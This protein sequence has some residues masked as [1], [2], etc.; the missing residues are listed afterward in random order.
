MANPKSPQNV[1][2]IRRE[3]YAIV[4]WDMV[5]QD[6]L[7][8]SI[9]VDAYYIYKSTTINESD[10]TLKKIVSTTDVVGNVDTIFLDTDV[11]DSSVYRIS[12]V[13]GTPP[14]VV[15]SQLS[16]K[17]VAIKD[18]SLIDGK[19]ELIDRKIGRFGVGRFGE[20]IFA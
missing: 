8:A 18:A 11:N 20:S 2:C 7:G 14:S 1:F 6:E 16:N 13:V 12:A 10:M 15:E 19:E 9:I 17:T 4:S 5:D 3:N